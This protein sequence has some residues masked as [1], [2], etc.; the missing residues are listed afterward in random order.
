MIE[1]RAGHVNWQEVNSL[2]RPGVVRLFT[3]QV[4]SRG[5]DAVLY[6][7][8]RQPRIGTE[9]FYGGDP[10]A[11][12]TRR[13]PGLPGNQPDRRGN[14]TAGAR[15]GRHQSRG[16]SVHSLQPRKRL[17]AFPAAAAQRAISACAIMCNCSTARCTTGISRWISRGRPT[18]CRATSWCWRPSLSLLSGG[19]SR[20]AQALRAKRRDAGGH[21]QLRP[22]G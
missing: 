15:L 10:D 8:W 20:R 9:K 5:A 19:G 18:I 1:Q 21:L 22:G 16:R 6:F 17:V 13:E 2:V 7:F 11:Q 3:Y 14:Q 4:L 12:R